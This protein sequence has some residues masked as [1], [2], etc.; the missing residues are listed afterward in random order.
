MLVE[1][2]RL[3][4]AQGDHHALAAILGSLDT[5][6]LWPGY[7]WNLHDPRV[8]A[9][10]ERARA[11]PDLSHRD[12]TQLTMALAGEL[13]YADNARSNEL[14]AAA[15]AMAAPLDDP[16]LSARILLQW[17]WS[18]SGPTGQA[19][20]ASIGDRLIR[21]DEDVALPARLRPLTHL[22]RVSAALEAGDADLARRCVARA[23]ALAHPVRTPTGWA[24]LQFAEAGLALL[25]GDLERARAHA[26]AL[27]P[28]LQRVRRYTADSSPASILAVVAVESGDTDAALGA[29]AALLESPYAAPIN[30]MAAWVLAEGGRAQDA[31]DALAGFD[32]PLPEDWLGLPLTTA[33][34]NAAAAVGDVRFLR[35]HLP[36]LLPFAEHFAFVG[37][38]GPCLG[39]VALALAAAQ[40]ALGDPAAARVHAERARAISERM[41]AVLWLP[42]VHRLLAALP[43]A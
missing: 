41:G 19:Q 33:A 10:V 32:G 1:A 36:S 29:L 28:A 15:E 24:H 21:L 27:R 39:P 22:A 4:E 38:G 5:E 25:D 40:R 6:S 26:V 35:R 7:D 42:R 8:V 17:F 11:Q 34:V 30:W 37:E 20:R 13:T 3:A 31:R 14:F 18:V 43:P 12:R 16:V 23:R 2:A 9:A